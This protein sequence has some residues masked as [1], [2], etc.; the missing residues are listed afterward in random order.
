MGIDHRPEMNG[1]CYGRLPRL[2]PVVILVLAMAVVG[3]TS[4]AVA[5]ADPCA[6]FPNLVVCENAKPGNPPRR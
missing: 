1:E 5:Q 3:A 6:G 4:R 2:L